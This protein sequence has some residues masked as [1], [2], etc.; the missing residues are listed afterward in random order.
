MRLHGKNI[1]ILVESDFYEPEIYY[2][3]HRFAEEGAEAH[4]LSRLWGQPSIEF[5]GHE[6]RAPFVCD[7]S[8][9][10]LSDDRDLHGT[11]LARPAEQR[12]DVL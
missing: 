8:F 9:E 10:G 1:A 7:E 12:V 11:R 2:Y 3:Q 4:F 6:L 5:K